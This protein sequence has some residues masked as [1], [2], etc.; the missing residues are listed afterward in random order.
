[1][2]P[3]PNLTTLRK[4]KQQEIDKRLNV[5]PGD[6]IKNIQQPKFSLILEQ[7][8]VLDYNHFI[9]T[10]GQICKCCYMKMREKKIGIVN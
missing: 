9:V 6:P 3:R 2:P 7:Y 8:G 10:T 5:Q 1:M 4:A